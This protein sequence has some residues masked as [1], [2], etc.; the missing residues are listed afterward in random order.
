MVASLGNGG[1]NVFWDPRVAAFRA[2]G[3]AR[4]CST[5]EPRWRER[6]GGFWWDSK[7]SDGLPRGPQPP[8]FSASRRALNACIFAVRALFF[9][10]FGAL[11]RGFQG[12]S[13]T[14]SCVSFDAST[15][16]RESSEGASSRSAE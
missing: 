2:R 5:V 9:T 3:L 16:R 8:S 11:E 15:A 6:L 14:R 1:L 12:A 10:I 4:L 13:K 7:G